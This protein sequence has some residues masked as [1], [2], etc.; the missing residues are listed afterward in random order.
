MWK[1][2]VH[3]LVD[4]VPRNLRGCGIESMTTFIYNSCMGDVCI[5]IPLVQLGL[6][7]HYSIHGQR[8]LGRSVKR[9]IVNHMTWLV[10]V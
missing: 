8:G 4:I 7:V 5:F 10:Y 1:T 9:R 2:L 3:T 6:N